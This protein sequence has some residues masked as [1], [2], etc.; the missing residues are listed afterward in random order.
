MLRVTGKEE[1]KPPTEANALVGDLVVDTPFVRGTLK[2]WNR[3]SR[4]TCADAPTVEGTSFPGP[5]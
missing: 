3:F 4:L 5:A 2:T 1:R